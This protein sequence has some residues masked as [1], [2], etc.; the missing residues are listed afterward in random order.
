MASTSQS[1]TASR[2]PAGSPASQ[3][4]ASS[5][6]PEPGGAPRT[7]FG[8]DVHP[9]GLATQRMRRIP[10][11][12]RSRSRRPAVAGSGGECARPGVPGHARRIA[13]W[14]RPRPRAGP[15]P[16][17]D[18]PSRRRAPPR[19]GGHSNQPAAPAPPAEPVSSLPER[20]HGRTA[21]RAT[22]DGG[23]A[24][25]RAPLCH[26]GAARPHVMHLL[27][28]IAEK[29]SGSRASRTCRFSLA[30]GCAPGPGRRRPRKCPGR[31]SAPQTGSGRPESRGPSGASG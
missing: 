20:P 26:A 11:N 10:G 23:L 9:H 6:P 27:P 2:S 16:G 21:G 5:V 31:G 28:A 24:P 1:V 14:T 22:P 30:G 7:G 19:C 29:R 18:P 15:L 13:P 8:H 3:L 17:S 25:R 4:P 12:S